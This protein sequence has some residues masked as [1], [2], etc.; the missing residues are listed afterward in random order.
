MVV[1]KSA[2]KKKTP[3]AKHLGVVSPDGSVEKSRQSKTPPQTDRI[4][5]VDGMSGQEVD[6]RVDVKEFLADVDATAFD[7]ALQQ[8]RSLIKKHGFKAELAFLVSFKE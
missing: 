3:G 7:F 1:P 4:L 6:S 8:F 5:Y 2:L